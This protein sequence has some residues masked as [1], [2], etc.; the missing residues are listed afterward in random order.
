MILGT[1]ILKGL[2]TSFKE[3]LKTTIKGSIIN[4]SKLRAIQIKLIKFYA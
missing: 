2:S 4:L 1:Y 3:Y